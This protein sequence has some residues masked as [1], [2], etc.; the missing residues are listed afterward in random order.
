MPVLLE[1]VARVVDQRELLLALERAR[2]GVCLVV[3][4]TVTGVAQQRRELGVGL[5]Q[6]HLEPGDLGRSAR[7]RTT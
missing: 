2:T 1:Q 7:Q 6:L 4:R 3:A 5:E